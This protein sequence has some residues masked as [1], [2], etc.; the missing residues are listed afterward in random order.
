MNESVA[1]QCTSGM[2]QLNIFPAPM[3]NVNTTMVT[4]GP[5]PSNGSIF[6]GGQVPDISPVEMQAVGDATTNDGL[7]YHFRT[8]YNRVVLLQDDDFNLSNERQAQFSGNPSVFL[9][10]DR[11]WQCTFTETLIEGYIYV[12][13][14]TTTN[15]TNTGGDLVNVTTTVRLPTVPYVVRLVEERMPTGKAPY[16]EKL[17]VESDGSLASSSERIILDLSDPEAE[18]AASTSKVTERNKVQ[19]RQQEEASNYCRCQWLV[20]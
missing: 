6:Y 18:A 5:L 1:W 16:C 9:P 2:I 11:L 13:K 8:T 10:G 14:P 17:L 12:S 7:V 3:G 19:G 4:M 20:Q 15:M